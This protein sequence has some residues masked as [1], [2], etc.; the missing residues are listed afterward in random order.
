MAAAVPVH[1]AEFSVSPVRI[2][3]TPRDRAVAVTITNDGA[4]EIVMQADLYSWKQTADGNDE[5]KLTEDLVLSPPILKVGPRSRQVVRLARLT[6]PPTV[7]EQTYRL[8]VREV[9]EAR[10]R[11]PGELGLQVAL[12]FSLPIFIT[13]PGAKRVMTCEVMRAGPEAVNAT[14][15]NNGRAY[16]Q[17]RA[18]ELVSAGGERVATRETGGYILPGVKRSFEIVKTAGR[19]PGGKMK[20]QVAMDDGTTQSFEVNLPE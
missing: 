17:A 11:P 8:V 18:L 3:M 14:C 4:E 12:A 19:I 2:F 15:E 16:A 13:P 6:P 5:L 1:A 10:P 20:L 7:E 9:P